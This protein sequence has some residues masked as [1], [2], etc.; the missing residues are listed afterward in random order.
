MLSDIDIRTPKDYSCKN[1]SQLHIV[2]LQ[3]FYEKKKMYDNVSC[4]ML[5]SLSQQLKERERDD[6][7]VLV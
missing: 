3:F 7:N 2:A 5:K 6:G 1:C 4:G